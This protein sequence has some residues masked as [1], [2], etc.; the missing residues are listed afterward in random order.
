MSEPLPVCRTDCWPFGGHHVV[1]WR[2]RLWQLR[3]TE[4][5]VTTPLVGQA[6]A[7]VDRDCR[8]RKPPPQS[9]EGGG[10]HVR[11]PTG[12]EVC[13]SNWLSPQWF[14]ER[15]LFVSAGGPLLPVSPLTGHD[16]LDSGTLQFILA[17]SLAPC[18]QKLSNVES[19]VSTSSQLVP[20]VSVE[21]LE[22]STPEV[23]WQWYRAQSSFAP[24]LGRCFPCLFLVLLFLRPCWWEIRSL[25]R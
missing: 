13:R 4:T 14:K 20:E 8:G 24:D 2:T 25:S 10:Q 9:P 7:D 17:Q 1:A 12:T 16:G 11:W 3:K 23:R 22:L 19:M 21:Q 15:S 6:R 18:A 5:G